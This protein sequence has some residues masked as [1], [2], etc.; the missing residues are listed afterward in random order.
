MAFDWKSTG[1]PALSKFWKRASKVPILV[2]ILAV[3][4]GGSRAV[5][6]LRFALEVHPPATYLALSLFW[7]ISLMT[8]LQRLHGSLMLSVQMIAVS[9]SFFLVLLYL[10]AID[11][12]KDLDYDRRHNPERPLVRGDVGTREVWCFAALIASAVMVMNAFL[13]ARLACFL[14]GDMAYGI[15]LLLLE[16]YS[17]G[18]RLSILLN[19]AL[20]FPV[21]A[22]LNVYAYLYLLEQGSAPDLQFVWPLF[23]AYMAAFLHFE[24]GRKLKWAHLTASDENGYANVLGTEGALAACWV[25]AVLACGLSTLMHLQYGPAAMSWMPWL[26]LFPS[27]LGSA[28]FLRRPRADLVLKPYFGA[29]L[30]LFFILNLAV[31]L[32]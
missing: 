5:R 12:I 9:A 23:A 18:F 17:P 4:P 11:E 28:R 8:L 27:L 26:A 19:L 6:L 21:S 16:R 13:S 2:R 24:F 30:L 25:F 1:A 29:F 32:A 7:S 20:T 22:A 15:G 3:L 31:A 14:A 10:R